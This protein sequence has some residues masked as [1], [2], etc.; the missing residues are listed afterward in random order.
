[1]VGVKNEIPMLQRPGWE[2][3][4]LVFTHSLRLI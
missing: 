3:D 2:L 4:H 1:M